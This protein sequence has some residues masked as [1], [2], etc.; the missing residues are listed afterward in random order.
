VLELPEGF[1][2]TKYLRRHRQSRTIPWGYYVTDEEP[3]ILVPNPAHLDTLKLALPLLRE[4]T[5]E[6]V[7][8]WLSDVT[9]APISGPGL[10]KLVKNERFRQ[11]QAASFRAAQTRSANAGKEYS[12]EAP[13]ATYYE[14]EDCQGHVPFF[15]LR[16]FDRRITAKKRR[17]VERRIADDRWRAKHIELSGNSDDEDDRNYI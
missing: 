13:K 3:K 10:F 8:N 14:T 9:K 1:G 5:Y 7:A 15:E 2:E 11:Y 16:R 17:A 6:A 12:K 4:T